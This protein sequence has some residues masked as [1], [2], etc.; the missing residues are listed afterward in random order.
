MLAGNTPRPLTCGDFY[1]VNAALFIFTKPHFN[2][3]INYFCSVKKSMLTIASL[4]TV[5][6]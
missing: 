2:V 6:E 1:I 4:L 3:V 5:N